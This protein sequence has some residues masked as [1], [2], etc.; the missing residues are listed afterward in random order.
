MKQIIQIKRKR[1]EPQLEFIL[2][3]SKRQKNEIFS[4]QQDS[5]DCLIT[6]VKN[7]LDDLADS[8]MQCDFKPTQDT[9]HV[10]SSRGVDQVRVLEIE[11][12]SKNSIPTVVKSN[13]YILSNYESMLKQVL[14]IDVDLSD[15]D[16]VYDLYIKESSLV[17]D[18]L[19][20]QLVVDDCFYH[21]Q[22]EIEEDSDQDSNH[23]DFYKNEYPEEIESDE[24]YSDES[25]DSFDDIY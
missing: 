25:D 20:P 11:K 2:I 15:T 6:T 8:K 18:D 4:L 22:E 3:Q 5:L 19:V 13:D 9:F 1:T 12:T 16:F 14:N 24:V 10:V 7:K 17:S 23:E 21:D